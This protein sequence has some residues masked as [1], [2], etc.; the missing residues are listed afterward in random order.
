MGVISF[1]FKI[2]NKSKN[3]EA[4]ACLVK[5]SHGNFKT[6][7]FVPVATTATVRA[8]SSE[9]VEN[10]GAEVILSNTYHLHLR[11]GDK[12]IKKIGG[13]HKF[14]SWDKPIITDSGGFQAFSLGFGMEHGVG[15]IGNIFPRNKDAEKNKKLAVV[16][17]K[18][19][20]FK[21]P[22]DGKKIRL[23]PEKSIEI[24]E[25]LGADIILAF[26]E[27]TSPFSDYSY[28]KLAMVRTHQ[29]AEECLKAHKNKKQALFG[30]VQGGAYK[31]LRR[32]SAQFISS[33][34]F[35]GYAVGGSLGKSK[36]DMHKILEWVVPL[37]DKEKPRHLL[38][39]G[40]VD[41]LFNC[42]E[43]GI[44]MF[45]C[46][47]PTR[48]ARR[49]CLYIG[50]KDNGNKKNKFRMNIKRAKFKEDKKPISKNCNCYTCRNFSRAYLRHLCM[51]NELLYFRLASLHNLN[52][53]LRLMD[54][55]RDSIK[56]N[57]FL[58][59]KKEWLR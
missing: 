45:D 4:R 35:D 9:D 22:I 21:S 29:W 26:D 20:S 16:D 58:K 39:I 13:L 50:P 44:D 18:G 3:S 47:S 53:I 10:L 15:K 8:L 54:S 6:P 34:G 5:T 31:D 36:K 28:T 1:S 17:N 49:G 42:V 46:V 43:R 25:N 38:G 12:L 37:L 41:D 48:W 23:T 51:S 40:G 56:N 7:A 14:M 32:K 11:P 2:I 55:I 57:Y 33:L 59:L 24:Q 27:C 30:I 52:F 19:V